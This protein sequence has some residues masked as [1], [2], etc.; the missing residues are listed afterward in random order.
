MF[1][2]LQKPL[3]ALHWLFWQAPQKYGSAYGI[4]RTSLSHFYAWLYNVFLT[5][6]VVPWAFILIWYLVF[7]QRCVSDL[8]TR[9]L[10]E[11][12][13]VAPYH[14]GVDVELPWYLDFWAPSTGDMVADSRADA[15]VTL[16]PRV[17]RIMTVHVPLREISEA[18][19][20][21]VLKIQ[22]TAPEL[23]PSETDAVLRECDAL[24]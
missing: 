22:D 6:Y 23:L 14:V 11:W 21:Q 10:G 24:T 7:C 2:I 16:S 18:L 9:I 15:H 20:K 8:G 12:G 13:C 19:S 4:Q 5:L 1:Q 17:E 3:D